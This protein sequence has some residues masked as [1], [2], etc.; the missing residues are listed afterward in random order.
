MKRATAIQPTGIPSGRRPPT[1][2]AVG[3][4]R[5]AGAYL[6]NICGSRWLGLPPSPFLASPQL[7]REVPLARVVPRH[8][9]RAPYD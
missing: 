7:E 9:G 2:A 8:V 4:L 3:L 6:G 1:S 5:H